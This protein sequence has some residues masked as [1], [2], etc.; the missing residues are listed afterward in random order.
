M[1]STLSEDA[2]IDFL[3]E[4]IKV[5]PAIVAFSKS[6]AEVCI[7]LLANDG[8]EFQQVLEHPALAPIRQASL[9]LGNMAL[10]L[11]HIFCEEAPD[12]SCVKGLSPPSDALAL[13]Y[14]NYSGSDIFERSFRRV[15]RD[16]WWASEIQ[17]MVKKGGSEVLM[18]KS[19]QEFTEFMSREPLSY[20]ELAQATSMLNDLKGKIRTQKLGSLL[21]KFK[22]RLKS[23]TQSLRVLGLR[24]WDLRM[25]CSV[26]RYNGIKGKDRTS[27]LRLKVAF[28]VVLSECAVFRPET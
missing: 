23:F 21:D 17:D 13:F 26:N 25:P 24:S 3:K 15:L 9:R 27:C 2:F 7:E 8:S 6:L 22:A 19:V 28:Q 10:C 4:G 12:V 11:L 1:M 20:Q 14:Y 5:K 18:Q 16:G